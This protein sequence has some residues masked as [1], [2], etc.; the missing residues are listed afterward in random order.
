MLPF[1][2]PSSPGVG[3]VCLSGTWKKTTEVIQVLKPSLMKG[4]SR[5]PERNTQTSAKILC[6]CFFAACCLSKLDTLLDSYAER[7]KRCRF[8][9]SYQYII[10]SR[11][12]SFS[13]LGNRML[14]VVTGMLLALMTNRF[15]FLRHD[16]YH[17]EFRNARGPDM[18]WW[19]HE[20]K[21]LRWGRHNLTTLALG[22]RSI[23]TMSPT[24]PLYIMGNFTDLWAALD[25]VDIHYDNDYLVPLLLSNPHYQGFFD[26][27]F[28]LREVFHPLSRLLFRLH[29]R[30]EAAAQQ[31]RK[32]NFGPF[33]VGLQIR[34]QKP[35]G[36]GLAD[37]AVS[38]Y[39][40][41]AR[42]VQL[43]QNIPDDQIKFFVA[44]DSEKALAEVRSTLGPER[45]VNMDGGAREGVKEKTRAGDPGT[46]ESAVLDMRLLSMT[47]ALLVT[48]ASSFGYVAAAWGG[49]VP[50]HV[51][52]RGDKPLMLNPYFYIPMDTEPCYWGAHRYFM[53]K[54]PKEAVDL[55]RDNPMWMQYAHCQ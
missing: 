31:F 7:H 1:S 52:H 49:I 16:T 23:W 24:D 5:S 4:S 11:G 45:V 20:A 40:T 25:A 6:L 9:E 32:A 14:S 51:L 19:E 39:C 37:P 26:E 43:K 54:A 44:T 21:L 50:I 38:Q 8:D 30:T 13:G 53:E 12:D 46:E 34:T 36:P 15:F 41:L 42:A 27:Y 55:L 35:L 29:S 22:P 10:V 3:D 48:S 18:R 2:E 17:R 28:P 47:D 33:T